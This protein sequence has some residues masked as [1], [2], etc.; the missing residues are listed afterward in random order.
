[1]HIII[2]P[3]QYIEHESFDSM[4]DSVRLIVSCQGS[5][6][7]RTGALLKMLHGKVVAGHHHHAVGREATKTASI[8]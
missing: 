3:M 1:M 4:S 2:I 8:T 7:R 5:N 6:R